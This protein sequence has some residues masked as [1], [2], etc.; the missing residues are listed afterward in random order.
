MEN[1]QNLLE[2][3]V[4][5]CNIPAPTHRAKRGGALVMRIETSEWE[6]NG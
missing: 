4:S 6:P 3:I 2:K 5:L 1:N